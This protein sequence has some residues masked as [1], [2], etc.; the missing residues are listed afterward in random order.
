MQEGAGAVEKAGGA[1]GWGCAG[2]PIRSGVST[3]TPIT[4][5]PMIRTTPRISSIEPMMPIHLPAWALSRPP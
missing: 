1:A 2:P 3:A 5:R 4:I